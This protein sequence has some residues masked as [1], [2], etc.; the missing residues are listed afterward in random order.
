MIERKNSENIT[1]EFS[2]PLKF[3]KIA[4]NEFGMEVSWN[5]ISIN[6]NNTK[7]KYH[8]GQEEFHIVI[9]GEF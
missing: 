4:L 7:F 2:E 3:T 6:Y 9:P 1:S 5:S 8:N